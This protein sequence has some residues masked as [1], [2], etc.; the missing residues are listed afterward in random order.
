MWG[1]GHSCRTALRRLRV[2]VDIN[3]PTDQWLMMLPASH[4]SD[5]HNKRRNEHTCELF[6]CE[7][8]EQDAISV[9]TPTTT[10][11]LCM[12]RQAHGGSSPPPA[13][14]QIYLLCPPPRQNV[15]RRHVLAKIMLLR[16][17]GHPRK[18]NSSVDMHSLR[19]ATAQFS[20][21]DTRQK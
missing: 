6:I 17:Y 8:I 20:P 14:T 18:H 16:H 15:N 11:W 2:L 4:Q 9:H 12:H 10:T 7:Q 5:L 1:G 19:L 13:L 3:K 21:Y